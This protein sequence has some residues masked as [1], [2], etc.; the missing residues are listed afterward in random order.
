MINS[1]SNK[2]MV[3]SNS[4]KGMNKYN[5]NLLVFLKYNKKIE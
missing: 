5:L 1:N 2:G 3:N 4:N